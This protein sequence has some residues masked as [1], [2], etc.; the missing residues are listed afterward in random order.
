ME[1]NENQD[2]EKN[3]AFGFDGIK[4]KKRKSCLIDEFDSLDDVEVNL[5]LLVF[6]EVIFQIKCGCFD[7]DNPTV[8]LEKID[9]EKIT[10]NEFEKCLCDILSLN[11]SISIG[12]TYT[13][14]HFFSSIENDEERKSAT[15]SL[16]KV[17]AS[18]IAIKSRKIQKIENK[19]TLENLFEKTGTNIF[20]LK[21][22]HFNFIRRIATFFIKNHLRTDTPQSVN[23]KKS[24]ASIVRNI[25][26]LSDGFSITRRNEI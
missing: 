11:L 20:L 2:E 3:E 17:P 14:M 23:Q 8:I 12:N 4:T 7:I 24:E 5:I 22:L 16:V 13:L 19:K 1:N 21:I 26:A 10:Q 18:Y 15:F 6:N 9:F 25:S